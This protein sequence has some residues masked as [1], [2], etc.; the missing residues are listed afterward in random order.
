MSAVEQKCSVSQFRGLRNT[1]MKITLTNFPS[2]VAR[3]ND[4]QTCFH[5]KRLKTPSKLH[6]SQSY[7]TAE[8]FV[9]TSKPIWQLTYK[10]QHWNVWLTSMT[11]LSSKLQSS[12]NTVH[13]G[14]LRLNACA[15]GSS[16]STA[17]NDS[18]VPAWWRPSERP[19]EKYNL[20]LCKSE[21]VLGG[22]VVLVTSSIK[23]NLD[24]PDF[25]I[26]RTFSDRKSV[27]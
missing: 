2:R 16:F 10:Y 6:S 27:V 22:S 19:G 4:C 1:H 14:L 24:Y 20:K 26:I 5:D 25:S 23:S 9:S 13:P 15:A 21:R 18:A 8:Q 12:V 11:S 7:P 3:P 17:H